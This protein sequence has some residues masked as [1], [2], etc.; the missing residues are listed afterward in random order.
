MTY[1]CRMSDPGSTTTF[2]ALILAGTRPG[3]D[4]LARALAVSHKALI[5]VAD[6]PMIVRVVR[7]LR[8]SQA[9]RRIAITGMDRSTL[10][11][12]R[13]IGV[14]IDS[15]ELTILGGRATPS[16]S[17]L[18][19]LE[20]LPDAAPLLVTTADHPLLS[21]EMIDEFAR[22]AADGKTDVAVGLVPAGAVHAAFPGVRRTVLPLR[23]GSYCGCNLF[24]F[25]TERSRRAPAFWAEIERHRKRPWRMLL[26]LGV[27][28]VL[29]FALRRLS[30]DDVVA[31]A[32]RKMDVRARAVVLSHPGAGFD[33]DKVEHLEAAERFLKMRG[34]SGDR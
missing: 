12:I 23:G 14:V 32:S 21:T 5:P 20:E 25:L 18:A 2:T 3:G 17:V 7:A 28:E 6:V 30:L 16:G 15:E 31:L 34:A 4:P 9:I 11:E 19:A 26:P 1:D 13:E 22:A 24:A 10:R 33:I 8:A 29:R 27:S